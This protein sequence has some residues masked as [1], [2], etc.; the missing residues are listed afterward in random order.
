MR[1]EPH[2]DEC[3]NII[4]YGTKYLEGYYLACRNFTNKY[5]EFSVGKRGKNIAVIGETL[6]FPQVPTMFISKCDT[7]YRISN[8]IIHELQVRSSLS[9]E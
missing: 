4:H 1:L 2:V 9:T 8:D 3:G 7:Y 5:H 6:F